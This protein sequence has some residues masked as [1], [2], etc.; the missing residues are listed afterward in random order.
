MRSFMAEAVAQAMLRFGKTG[1]NPAVG[2]VLV[3]G[4][5]VVAVGTHQGAGH[6]HAEIVALRAAEAAGVTLSEC[7]L[8]V[9]LEPCS[10]TGRTGPC[11]DAVIAAGIRTVVYGTSDPNP[12]VAGR[13][14]VKLRKAGVKVIGPVNEDACKELIVD[15]TLAQRE[16]RAFV[17]AKAGMTLD[18]RVA[19]RSKHSKWVTG[20]E[21]RAAGRLLRTQVQAIAVGVGTVLADDPALSIAQAGEPP[22]PD[23]PLRVIFDSTL[24]TPASAYVV[25]SARRFPTLFICSAAAPERKRKLLI[26]SGAKLLVMKGKRVNI[27]AALQRLYAEHGILRLLVEGGPT[28]TGAFADAGCVDELVLFVAPKLFGGSAAPFVGGTGVGAIDAALGFE[29]IGVERVGADLMLRL[30]RVASPPPAKVGRAKLTAKKK[31]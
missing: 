17:V 12:Q 16:Q 8:F 26:A 10:H 21:A 30:R 15:F 5:A 20:P 6:P 24:R 4:D 27:K 19:T 14:L 22:Q 9:T 7:T 2:A 31:R 1:P 28:L 29:W 23:E 13:G 25:R 3:R 11:A 18:A